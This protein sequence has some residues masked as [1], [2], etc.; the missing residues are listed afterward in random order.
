M[1]GKKTQ[2]NKKTAYG[3]EKTFANHIFDKRLILEK[4]K[5]LTKL[6]NKQHRIQVKMD[7]RPD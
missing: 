2:Q 4:Y 3:M 5:E 7:N 6:N 1:N